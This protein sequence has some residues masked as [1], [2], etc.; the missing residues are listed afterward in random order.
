MG[1]AA[2][3]HKK[4]SNVDTARLKSNQEHGANQGALQNM[5]DWSQSVSLAVENAELAQQRASSGHS[6]ESGRVPDYDWSSPDHAAATGANSVPPSIRITPKSRPSQCR[7]ISSSQHGLVLQSRRVKNAK[8]DQVLDRSEER[9]KDP[10]NGDQVDDGNGD[11]NE[12][13]DDEDGGEGDE[14]DDNST[15]SQP[16]STTST[17]SSLSLPNEGYILEI[18]RR[19]KRW[20]PAMLELP[21]QRT[22]R[23][24][25]DWKNQKLKSEIL[26]AARK[27]EEYHEISKQKQEQTVQLHEQTMRSHRETIHNH[28]KAEQQVKRTEALVIKFND[29]ILS[30]GGRL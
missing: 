14:E 18:V 13:E 24:E 17:I 19:S 25:T 5:Y 16:S 23:C 20:T 8:S 15:K 1:E 21:K 9:G 12:K 27:A 6:M 3:Q 30:Q 22:L 2:Q 11:E 26:R 4:H 29:G 10:N 28:K 7:E